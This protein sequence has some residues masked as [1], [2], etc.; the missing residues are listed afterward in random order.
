MP[1]ARSAHHPVDT[2]GAPAVASAPTDALG[3]DAV[4]H[5]RE[6]DHLADVRP[7]R[8]PGDGP[9]QPEAETRVGECPVAAEVEVPAIRCLG[10][11]FAS[12]PAQQLLEVVGGYH[13]VGVRWPFDRCFDR[14]CVRASNNTIPYLA[15]SPNGWVAAP[16]FRLTL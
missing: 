8:D 6:G 2:T 14:P 4:E 1:G 7:S 9:F 11:A 16:C 3:V 10:Q 15:G 12:D 13:L 5:P